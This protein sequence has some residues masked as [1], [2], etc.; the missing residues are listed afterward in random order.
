VNTP[1]RWSRI[2]GI[3]GLAGMLIGAIDPLEG[4]VVILPGIGLVTLGAFLGRSRHRALLLWAFVLAAIGVGTMFVLSAFGGVGGGTG[5]SMWWGLVIA[6]YPVGW[7][8][9]LV[10]AI[11]WMVESFR[12]HANSSPVSLQTVDGDKHEGGV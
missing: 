12:R 7:I 1:K 4:S 9:G 8:M 10:G 11:R 3:V 5:R 2:L 6:P